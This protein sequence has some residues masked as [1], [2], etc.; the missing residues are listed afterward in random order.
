M[1]KKTVITFSEK[2]N[3][4][5]VPAWKDY[6]ANYRAVNF[7]KK[8]T[9]DTSKT[10]DEKQAMM[11]KMIEDEVLLC[12]HLNQDGFTSAA[13]N[14]TNPLY[15]W[16]KFAVVNKLIDMV[17]PDVIR[18]DFMNIANVTNLGYGDSADFEIKSGDLFTVSKNG[19][20]RRHVDAQRQFTGSKTLVPENHTI[21][22]EY[23]LYRMLAGKDSPAEYAMK[24][25]LSMESE[26]AID[27]ISCLTNAYSSLTANFKEA[28]FSESA[29]KKLATRVTAANGGAK[30]V[31]IGTDIAVGTLLPTNDYLKMELG[32]EYNKV[33][34]LPVFKGVPV[35]GIGQKIDWDSADYDF[36]LSD[37]YVYILS[38]QTQKLVQIVFEGDALTIN[39]GYTDGAN[40]TIKN[41]LH[42]RW[43]V[44]LITNAHFGIMKVS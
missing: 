6:V 34:Y 15:Q 36:A 9:Y 10:L 16:A 19:N 43:K 29:F 42:K 40:L 30:A 8:N 22:V 33:G 25:I 32:E 38:P 28:A 27:I 23:D 21:T 31:A 14:A 12:A 11:D 3:E 26:I 20:S 24:V 4:L 41:S 39:E 2:A 17:I 18:D 1:D 37:Q 7:A 44:G 35:I 13:A 5:L